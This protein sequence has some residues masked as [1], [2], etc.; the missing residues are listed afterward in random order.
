MK[1]LNSFTLFSRF[2]MIF[3]LGWS[4]MTM[5]QTPHLFGMANGGG[6][7]E[8]GTIFSYY[9]PASTYL[10]EYNFPN[11]ED[12]G[13]P[14]GGLIQ[15]SN[16]KLYGLTSTSGTLFEFDVAADV[17]TV[18]HV[19]VEATDG[20]RPLG[21][22]MEASNGKL[23]GTTSSG[24]NNSLG[25][26][27]SYDLLTGTF[28]VDHHFA[29]ADSGRP[30]ANGVVEHANG[31]LYGLTTGVDW[32][33]DGMLYEFDPQS[34]SFIVK[35]VFSYTTGNRPS[36]TLV[37]APNGK[38]YATAPDGGNT[39]EGT[40]FE[41]D[42]STNQLKK[43]HDFNGK[44]GAWPYSDLLV[45]SDNKLYGLTMMGGIDGLGVL[46]QY[47]P[48][49]NKQSVKARF[50]LNNGA[51]PKGSLM[52]ASDGLIYGMALMGGSKGCGTL[53][54]YDL[55]TEKMTKLVNLKIPRGCSPF[56]G[57]LVEYVPLAM[58]P[59]RASGY[60]IAAE[61]TAEVFQTSVFPNPATSMVTVSFDSEISESAT[62]VV[63]DILGVSR[64]S[65]KI[66]LTAGVNS[67]QIDLKSFPTGIYFVTISCK[68][69][70][71]VTRLM[72][73]H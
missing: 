68:Q 72:V 60:L 1:P 66:N 26:L 56:F 25:T 36:G 2:I 3:L 34:G 35:L 30:D 37:R 48:A 44:S 38:Y 16:G 41:Y 64:Y 45:A 54:Q 20:S 63:S 32:S 69:K 31:K 50:N 52:Q 71:S 67:A 14:Y 28:Q 70:K 43:I 33:D 73:Q 15:A 59:E 24:G 6:K 12:G 65:E 42:V 17:F 53:F 18:K 58:N 5:A 55:V 46:Y 40:L 61:S 21:T 13:N 39:N 4:G 57:A 49:T 47:D 19:F 29:V 10:V 51:W 11:S 27:F 9:P 8:R 23:Y 22:L 7:Y 62:L